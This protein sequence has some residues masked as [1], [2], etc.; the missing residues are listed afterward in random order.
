MGK[1]DVNCSLTKGRQRNKEVMMKVKTGLL[2]WNTSSKKQTFSSSSL[3]CLHGHKPNEYHRDLQ[4]C[5]RL[6]LLLMFLCASY[7]RYES[8]HRSIAQYICGQITSMSVNS[9]GICK[10]IFTPNWGFIHGKTM[11]VPHPV[12]S[13]ILCLTSSENTN[14]M[15]IRQPWVSNHAFKTRGQLQTHRLRSGK[16]PFSME[17]NAQ[18]N[19]H[20]FVIQTCAAF[21]GNDYFQ[22]GF[23]TFGLGLTL[24]WLFSY[25]LHGKSMM[26]SPKFFTF[27]QQGV[28]E[29]FK[30]DRN[31]SAVGVGLNSSLCTIFLI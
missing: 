17:K 22:M 25:K 4:V 9:H 21:G 3:E 5:Y 19:T 30:T 20:G 23:C 11:L 28:G 8:G 13:I 1:G 27:K 18:I 7:L 15:N 12:L 10:H 31:N 26:G 16:C 29:S 6:S 14:L 2:E 24:G